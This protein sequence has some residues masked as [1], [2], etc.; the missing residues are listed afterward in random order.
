MIVNILDSDNVNYN[1]IKRANLYSS[2]GTQY[3]LEYEYDKKVYTKIV[4]C[5]H[6]MQINEHYYIRSL[7][8]FLYFVTEKEAI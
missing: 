8:R 6:D 4:I 3:D 7:T 1:I 2:T 5:K